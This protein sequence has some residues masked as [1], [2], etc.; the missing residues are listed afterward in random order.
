MKIDLIEEFW[1]GMREDFRMFRVET[2]E[3]PAAKQYGHPDEIGR[4]FFYNKEHGLDDLISQMARAIEEKE[5]ERYKQE[6]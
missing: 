2:W 6:E 5:Y 4:V 1:P 3:T